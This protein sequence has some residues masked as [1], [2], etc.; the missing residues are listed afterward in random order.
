MNRH[1][2]GV[3]LAAVVLAGV[4]P[5]AAAAAPAQTA[6]PTCEYPMTS[7]DAT[8]TEVTV[9]EV[10]ERVVVTGASGAQTMW[11]LDASEQVVGMPV[12]SW[13]TYLEGAA[14]KQEVTNQDGTVN[15]EQTIAANP[16]LVLAANITSNQKVAQLREAGI[17]VY[18]FALADSIPFIYEKTNAT[19]AMTGNCGAAERVVSEMRAN[20]SAVRERA[21]GQDSPSA[22]VHSGGGYTATVGSFQ[23]DV[24]TT[25]G[26][27]NVAAELNT[28]A[29]GQVSRE[30]VI[31]ANPEYIVV[32]VANASVNP[33]AALP[34]A[35]SNLTAVQEDQVVGVNTNY[36]SQPAPRVTRPLV[37]L[38]EAFYGGEVTVEAAGSAT[39]PDG[40]EE[41][42]TTTAANVTNA[43]PTGADG[44]NT[45]EATTTA[46]GG[47]PGFGP[48]AVMAALAA[49]LFV[50]RRD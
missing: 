17:T 33:A 10:P 30:S 31:E 4:L 19:A 41:S 22:F 32:P 23:H 48:V 21:A 25:A 38:S 8:G 36:F 12:K 24:L 34:D 20:V 28:S 13:T 1:A 3:V 45:V 16:D 49:A 35:Y 46:S 2:I 5:G 29:Y 44:N 6:S 43:S 47:T 15:V 37:T 39:T 40:G 14:E 26:A 7:T 11:E 50:A 42:E 9:E 27:T 18:T